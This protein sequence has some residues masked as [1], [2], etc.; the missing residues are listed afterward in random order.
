MSHLSTAIV[1]RTVSLLGLLVLLSPSTARGQTQLNPKQIA[2]A[3]GDA[4][5]LI[6]AS[7]ARG[8]LA[9][10]GSGFLVT[11]DGMLVTN[12]HVI[13]D[14]NAL[15]VELASG[16]V[17]DS[18][19]FV[20]ADRQRDLAIL[21]IPAERLA[22]LRLGHDADAEVGERI[23]VMGNP[24][25][26]TRTFS[27]GL[28]SANRTIE[29]VAFVQITAP[30][31]PGSSGGPVMNGAGE[32]IAV[33]TMMLRGGQNLNYAVPVRYVRPLLGTGEQPQ[34]FSASL[35]PQPT[36]GLAAAPS[37]R[38]AVV[39]SSAPSLF[40]PRM[41]TD[42][43]WEAQVVRQLEQSDDVFRQNGLFRSQAIE[44]GAMLNRQA[45][46]HLIR[47][48]AGELFGIA[49]TC[50][51][52]CD[53]LNL[54]LYSPGGVLVESD[55]RVSD[56]PLMLYRAQVT[57]LYRVR[58]TMSSCSMTPCRYGIAVYAEQ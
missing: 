41:V 33:A 1:R 8:Q 57:G 36:T 2:A 45:E 29:G 22:S 10:T 27:D 26:M 19:L 50:D 28:V 51:S 38:P 30:L 47:L 48:Q 54:R 42:E 17:Y 43:Q 7:D 31:S 12:F 25:G 3:A 23:F 55:T 13:Q 32:V 14:A 21:K 24:L 5:V 6:R 39:S 4:T 53:D 34:R 37:P 15:Q 9:G 46:T 35:L 52:D 20:T 11:D 18:V 56:M 49:G 58:V 16:E 44:Q 40:Q